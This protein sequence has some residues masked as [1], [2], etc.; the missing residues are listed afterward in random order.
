SAPV[1]A[2]GLTANNW[3]VNGNVLPGN[4]P[5]RTVRISAYSTDFVPLN[6]IGTLFNLKISNV[7]QGAGSS[8]LMWAAPP[9]NFIFIN[10]DLQTQHPGNTFPGSVSLGATQR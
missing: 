4:G 2:A 5:I 3:N 9:E 1:E 10:A 7:N 6:G 8:P